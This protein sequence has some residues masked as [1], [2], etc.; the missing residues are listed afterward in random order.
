MNHAPPGSPL[1]DHDGTDTVQYLYKGAEFSMTCVVYGGSD[2]TSKW[3][4]TANSAAEAA[5]IPS[6][7]APTYDGSTTSM[8]YSHTISTIAVSNAGVYKCMNGDD[9]EY[10]LT[11]HVYGK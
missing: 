10:S 7:N 9:L 4:F 1:S 11:L 2:V 6:T 3:Y 8:T 5:I